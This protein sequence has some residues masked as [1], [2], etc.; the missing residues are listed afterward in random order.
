MDLVQQTGRYLS[1]F[2]GSTQN[3][4][5]RVEEISGATQ[6]QATR[7]SEITVSI[8]DM[9]QVTQ[10]NAAMVEETTAASH[11]LTAETRTLTQTLS[12]FRINRR[13][14][15]GPDN[16]APPPPPPR[17][18]ETVALKPVSREVAP[19]RPVPAVSSSLPTTSS[20]QGWEEF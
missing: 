1:E 2:S 11:N 7:L 20:D 13:K 17:P 6:D 10:Q 8:G 9:D 12:R 3:I 4:A 15:D 18:R 14:E 5:T 16:S 19:S